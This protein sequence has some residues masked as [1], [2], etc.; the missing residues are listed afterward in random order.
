MSTLILPKASPSL[1]DYP[2][3]ALAATNGSKAGALDTNSEIFAT[4]QGALET[5]GRLRL[6]ARKA[7]LLS[8]LARSGSTPL[9]TLA[10]AMRISPSATTTQARTLELLGLITLS[11]RPEHGDARQ[12]IG[13][14]TEAGRNVMAN[15]VALSGLAGAAS[16]MFRKPTPK[17]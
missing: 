3:L 12:V 13:T 10:R 9:G 17:L 8:L 4:V 14:I 2:E 16:I 1:A 6:G 15:I 5:V 7:H 11:R